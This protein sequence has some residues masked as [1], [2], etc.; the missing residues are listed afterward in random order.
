MRT[1][2]EPRQLIIGEVQPLE[3][4]AAELESEQDNLSVSEIAAR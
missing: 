4:Q 3:Q 1:G 2:L